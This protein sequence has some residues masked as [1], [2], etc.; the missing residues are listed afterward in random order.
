M[1]QTNDISVNSA[2]NKAAENIILPSDSPQWLSTFVNVYQQLSTD[3]LALLNDVYDNN[4]TF[5][6]PIHKVNGLNALNEYFSSLYEHLSA[7][8]FAIESVVYS[9][10]TAAIYWCMHFEHPKLNKGKAVCVHGNSHIKGENNK[11]IYHRDFFDVG[12]M[13]YEQLPIIGRLISWIKRKAS[14]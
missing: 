8:Q 7:C 1:T 5:E 2:T 10:N 9:N 6:D 13:L 12:A 4:I 3:N 11:V 14:Q